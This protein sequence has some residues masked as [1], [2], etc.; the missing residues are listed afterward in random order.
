MEVSAYASLQD[1]KTTLGINDVS[2]DATLSDLIISVSAWFDLVAGRSFTPQL[3]EERRNGD[4]TPS[5]VLRGRV[6]ENPDIQD[7]MLATEDGT[8]LVY[9]TDFGFATAADDGGSPLILYRLDGAGQFARTSVWAKG[10]KNLLLT[11]TTA[12]DVC[13]ADVR[14]ACIEEAGRA[15][16]VRGIADAPDSDRVG[17]TG[18]SEEVGTSVTF[19]ADDLSPGTRSMLTRWRK[20][21]EAHA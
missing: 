12:F 21:F 20:R 13:P 9:G 1:L 2:N 19:T 4:G 6:S 11:Y 7:E 5:L 10:F 16:R 17:L 15:Y 8:S 3:V 18:R 14:R